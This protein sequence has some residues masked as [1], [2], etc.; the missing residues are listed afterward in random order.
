MPNF[1][2]NKVAGLGA[3]VMTGYARKGDYVRVYEI[4]PIVP[5]IAQG[6]F[7][8]LPHAKEIGA[9]AD[10]LMGD[11]RLTMN[12]E[13]PNNYDVLAID[14]FS[15]DAIPVHL[16]T[17]ECFALYQKHLAPQGMLVFHV[18]NTH[19]DLAPVVAAAAR[20]IGLEPRLVNYVAAKNTA[21]YSSKWVIAASPETWLALPALQRASTA[22][23]VAP[24][25]MWTDDY[26]NLLGVLR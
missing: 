9:D 21:Y 15:G 1:I 10:I 20:T 23:A 12:A 5:G 4:N 8:F 18:T 3:G 17:R 2:V 13:A 7:K 14:A 24:E 26:S 6:E 11:A 22:L 19:L 25:K 16:L